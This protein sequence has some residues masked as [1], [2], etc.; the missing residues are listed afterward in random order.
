MIGTIINSITIVFASLIGIFIGDRLN[1]RIRLALMQALG[2]VVAI[3]GIDMALKTQNILIVIASVLLGTAIGEV[4][5][6]ED[7]LN[8]VG[9]RFERKFSKSK[10]AEGFV[11]ST[12]LFCVGSM[13]IVGPIQEG[14]TGDTSILMAKSM[15]DGISSIAL[16]STLGI[17][18]LFSSI[19]VFIY[20]GSIT[21]LS[22]FI[23]PFVNQTIVDELTATGGILIMA[24]A[25]KLLNLKDL[26]A[27]NMLP[28]LFVAPIIT[29]FLTLQ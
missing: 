25:I 3:I 14:L 7:W 4:L 26:R 13:A 5:G 6:I 22:R 27:G 21:I 17:G 11:T 15:L 12:L 24:I 23:E 29:Y 16:S 20:Q 8:R 18:V 9:S 1:N 28:A 10:F 2:L 19:A